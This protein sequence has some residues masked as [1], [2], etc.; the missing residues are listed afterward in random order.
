MIYY[1][2]DLHCDTAL[3]LLKGKR[4]D[5]DDG[6]VSLKRLRA[7]HIRLQVFACWVSPKYR[8][9]GAV[10]QAEK[11]IAAV[12]EE[13]E[14]LSADLQLVVDADSWASSQKQGKI[15]ILLGIEGAHALGDRLE[16]L[17]RFRRLGIRLLTLTWNNSN[18]FAC[19]AWSAEKTGRDT[20][21]TSQGRELL[22]E[23][24]RSGV[25]IDLSHASRK[26]FWDV[27]QHSRR[28]VIASHSCVSFYRKHFR[29]LD[30]EQIK[31]LAAC[32]GLLGINF[33]PGFLGER[34]GRPALA[35]VV[36]QFVYVKELAGSR[37]L[38][39]GSD[40]DGISKLPPGLEGPHKIPQLL[41]ELRNHDFQDDEIEQVALGNLL[42]LLGWPLVYC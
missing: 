1:S 32:G 34:S 35:E 27:L 4:L 38:A 37:V 6:H 23:A 3:R 5:G 41:Q 10:A 20:G 14:R 9:T 29:N 42:R 15:G 21:L 26:T 36:E 18:I 19:S 31:A 28:P 2:S 40:F 30:D 25:I 33:Y 22:A 8:R 16:N 24:G 39:L 13:T 11:L 12:I 7:G 17:E